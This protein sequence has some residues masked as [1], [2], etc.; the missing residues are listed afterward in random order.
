MRRT[1]FYLSVGLLAFGIC[2]FLLSS[3]ASA[4][5][6]TNTKSNEKVVDE[7]IIEESKFKEILAKATENLKD[8]TYRLT[9]T[10]ES[11]SDRNTTAI[12]LTTN[13]LE[14]IPPDK[15]RKI[16]EVKSPTKNTRSERIWDGKNLYTKEN[17]GDWKKYSGGSSSSGDFTS[18]RTTITYKFIGK[19]SLNGKTADVYESESH[20]IANKLT[21]TSQ[22]RVEYVIKTK[23]W[24]S[25][26]GL[27]LKSVKESEIVGSQS[28]VRE[29]SIYEYDSKIKIEAPIK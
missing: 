21:Q 25:E 26:D 20:R 1:L 18:G 9:K 19:E 14:R 24:F 12:S 22:Y 4:Q 5:E 3:C 10:E 29:V 27:F 23:Y 7:N 6:K 11:F 8:K 15:E 2:A 17:D 16:E 13:I 28:L